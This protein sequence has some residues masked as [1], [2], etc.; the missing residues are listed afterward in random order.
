MLR[1]SKNLFDV[2]KIKIDSG[3]NEALKLSIFGAIGAVTYNFKF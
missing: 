1:E 2:Q 3:Q